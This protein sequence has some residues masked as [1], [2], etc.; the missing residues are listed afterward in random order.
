MAHH[1]NAQQSM[2]AVR[3]EDERG[4]RFSNQEK[5]RQEYSEKFILTRNSRGEKS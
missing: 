1:W 2:R 4:Q 5:D 3:R